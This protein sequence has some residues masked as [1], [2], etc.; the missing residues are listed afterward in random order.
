MSM[1]KAKTKGEKLRAKKLSMH[2][3]EDIPRKQPNGRRRR[4]QNHMAE[5]SPERTVLEG[6]ARQSGLTPK[7]LNEMR[8]T[9]YGEAAGI[10][11]Y[12]IRQGDTAK[13]LWG[14]YNGVSGAYRRYLSICI[15]AS[16]DAKTAKLEMMPERFEVDVTHTPDT[17]THEERHRAASNAW[18]DWKS[19]L[20]RLPLGESAAIY[21]ALHGW[22]MLM[23][24]GKITLSGQRF[25]AA[26]ERLADIVDT[27]RPHR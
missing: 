7:D 20:A 11:I 22:G 9:A 21:A 15:G 3:L 18:A 17:R 19:A 10:A 14:A 2:D 8:A 1:T 4:P 13:R 25:V 12:T 16:V 26:I 5:D 23:D 6:R 27:D 24:A